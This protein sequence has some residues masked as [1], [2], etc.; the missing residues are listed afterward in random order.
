MRPR[1]HTSQQITA[2]LKEKIMLKVFTDSPITID[3]GTAWSGIAT[4]PETLQIVSGS[5]WVT[6]EGERH[7]Y[8]LSPGD[9][10]AIAPQRVV[11][12]EADH[13]DSR[14][15][16]VAPAPHRIAD[17]V[18]EVASTA[19][20]AARHAVSDRIGGGAAPRLDTEPCC[21]C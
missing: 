1:I 17:R 15:G 12:V 21:T 20:H 6:V 16:T 18:L 11:V 19:W 10:L 4:R 9:T 13:A 7:D 14:I 3:A 2:F 5:V 8:W